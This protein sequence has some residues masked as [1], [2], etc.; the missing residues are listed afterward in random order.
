MAG[1]ILVVVVLPA[2]LIT[3][4]GWDLASYTIPNT[5]Q[6][7]MIASFAIFAFAVGMTPE[8]VGTHALAGVAGI[9]AGFALFAFNLVGGGDAKLFG[10]T[11]LWFGFH[12]IL[13]YAL[14]VSL[15][16][17]GLTILMLAMRRMPLPARLASQAWIARLHDQKGGIPY[18][19]ALAA[20]AFVILPQTEIFRLAGAA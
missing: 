10:C 6:I 9:V 16:G 20:G 11:L 12:D 14:M 3:A 13:D 1:H 8:A 7:A 5:L 4:A 19:V 2:L 15:L 18:G 17:G